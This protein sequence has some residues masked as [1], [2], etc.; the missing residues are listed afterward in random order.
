MKFAY[1]PEV[2]ARYK[3]LN[4]A[5]E[6]RKSIEQFRKAGATVVPKP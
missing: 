3:M 4:L 1:C 2:Q 6:Q 5:A